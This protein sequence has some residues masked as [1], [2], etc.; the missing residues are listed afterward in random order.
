MRFTAPF[1]QSARAGRFVQRALRPAL[2]SGVLLLA[3]YLRITGL[4]WG[5]ASGYG[6]GLSFQPDEF[7]SLRGV[8]DIDLLH[9]RLRAPAAYWEGTFNYYL[10]ALPKA[11]LELFSEK[12]S[13]DFSS[14]NASTLSHLIYI[15]RW[16]TALFDLAAV[17]II[18]LAIREVGGNFYASLFGAFVYAVLPIEVI[19]AHYMR[20]HILSNLL[21]SLVLWL[22]IKIRKK[23]Q[24]WLLFIVGV[25]SG[26]GAATR[27][28]MGVLVAIPCLFIIL[29]PFEDS[30]LRARRVWQSVKNLL[31]GPVWLLL[32]G[33]GCGLFAGHPM[34]FLDTVSV[35]AAVEHDTLKWMPSNQF[36]VDRLLDLSMLWKYLSYLIPYGMYPLLWVICYSAII[37]LLFRRNS[38][39]IVLPILIFSLLYLY[40]MAKGYVGP[41]WARAAMPLFPGFCILIGLAINDLAI[42][43]K[44]SRVAVFVIP[45]VLVVLALPSM[46]FDVA[47]VQA[48]RQQDSRSTVRQ[49]L[50]ALIGPRSATIGVVSR[51]AGYFYTAMPAAEPLKNEKVIVQLQDIDQPA[52]F[53][54]VGFVGPLDSN[55]LSF[56][57]SKVEAQGRFKYQKT[58]SICPR[59]F[60]KELRLA[61]F[62]QDMTYPFPTILLFRGK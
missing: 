41:Y 34:L 48:M 44:Q 57:I 26:L 52:D 53:L 19:Y 43:L 38:Q 42:L 8:Q 16:M 7:L 28:P 55:L 17:V 46:A 20:P 21:C 5:I 39:Q 13:L 45:T 30:S 3:A 1:Q 49:D 22:S 9:A 40:P 6:H 59:I 61:Q 58:Y 33:F 14:T 25:I 60:G 50:Q 4:T 56:Y 23:R 24:P 47:Y 31:A 12:R 18:F 2:F 10:W 36:A 32:F 37:Y 35:I 51:V 29:A 11:A 62:P 15:C 27:F 54:L